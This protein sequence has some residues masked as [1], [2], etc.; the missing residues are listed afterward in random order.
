MRNSLMSVV[1]KNPLYTYFDAIV[2]YRPVQFLFVSPCGKVEQK[3]AKLSKKT[4]TRS[5][6]Q[7]G[8][9]YS[10]VDDSTFQQLKESKYYQPE[11]T[12]V[13]FDSQMMFEMVLDSIHIAEK[14]YDTVW[15]PIMFKTMWKYFQEG[16]H[17][18]EKQVREKGIRLRL[19]VETSKSN[20]DMV[21]SFEGYDI[22][23]LDDIKGNFGIFDNRAYMVYIFH[24]EGEVP[25][26]TL[27]SNS[28]ALVDKQQAIFDRLW[29]MAIPL[30]SRIKEL[31]YEENPDYRSTITGHNQIKNQIVSL[32]ENSKKELVIFSS[33][34][35]LDTVFQ[36][37]DFLNTFPSC[38]T[39]RKALEF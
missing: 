15:D 5:F 17:L 18:I 20:L 25:D 9:K 11:I 38:Q 34:K 2:I 19:I 29:E 37:N 28:K 13:M 8:Q 30:P 22:R 6:Y 7:M 1:Y 39:K 14:G 27:W 16:I 33:A 3:N 4:K 26:Q 12:E 23:H 24:K 36:E 32:L 31:E 35:I 21:S 10:K